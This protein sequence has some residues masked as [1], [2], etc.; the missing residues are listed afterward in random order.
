[1]NEIIFENQLRGLLKEFQTKITIS[2][3][4]EI[5]Y[6]VL[7]EVLTAKRNKAMKYM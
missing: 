5:T 6:K 1:M 3:M 2:E 4:E 7:N